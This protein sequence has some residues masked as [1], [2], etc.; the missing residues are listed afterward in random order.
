MRLHVV[1]SGSCGNCFYV[2]NDGQA[3]FI[4]MGIGPRILKKHCI[5]YGVP[6]HLIRAVLLTHDHAD[7]CR[8]VGYFSKKHFIPIYALADVFKGIDENHSLHHKPELTMR[9]FIAYN[10]PFELAGMRITPFFVPH[11]SRANT[12]YF[13]EAQDTNLCLMT[14]VGTFTPEMKAYIERAENLIVEANYDPE[15][16]QN[17][18]YAGIYIGKDEKSGRVLTLKD[19]VASGTGHSSNFETAD[20]L[21]EH[22]TPLTK[23]VFLCHLSRENNTP[24]LARAA[25][26]A[27]LDDI[28]HKATLVVLEH[29]VPTNFYDL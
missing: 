21:R 11:D 28:Q 20:T 13:I 2:E 14:D 27:A 29:G 17:G 7:H 24:E 12:G 19:R 3:L 26:Q 4:D 22:L 23:R 5:N 18:R 8:N 9:H 16:L 25:V 15:M 10:E 1:S 6:V